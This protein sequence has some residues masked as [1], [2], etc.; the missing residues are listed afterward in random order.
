MTV[1][2]I[3]D[4]LQESLANRNRER[5]DDLALHWMCWL[6]THADMLEG[7]LDDDD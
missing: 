5:D 2:E 3:L 4:K 6:E 7:L 1:T